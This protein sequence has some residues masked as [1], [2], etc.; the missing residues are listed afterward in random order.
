MRRRRNSQI[1]WELADDNV[2]RVTGDEPFVGAEPSGRWG[3]G[4]QFDEAPMDADLLDADLIMPLPLRH[5]F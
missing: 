4:S 1:S 2:V 5:A 3:L